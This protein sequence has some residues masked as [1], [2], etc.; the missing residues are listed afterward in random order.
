LA[1][2]QD[3]SRRALAHHVYEVEGAYTVTVTA[4]PQDGQTA[5][6]E[7]VAQIGSGEARLDGDDR[8]ETAISVS[9]DSFPDDG[10]ADAVLLA[11]ADQFADALSAAT[12]AFIEDAP[13]LL[14]GSDRLPAD[15]VAELARALGDSGT[16]YL[17]GGEAAIDP[18]IEQGLVDLGYEVVRLAG[19]D[20]IATALA[21]AEFVLATGAEVEEVVLA[22]AGDYPDALAGAAYAA[23]NDALILLTD[24]A[25]LDP[26]VAELLQQLGADMPVI[27]A[28]GAAAISDAVADELSALGFTVT[29]VDGADRFET[30][31]NLAEEGYDGSDTVV[32]A[33]GRTF[34]DALAGAAHAARLDAP[35]LLVSDVLPPAVAEFLAA[36]ADTLDTVYVLGG[37]GAVPDDVLDAAAALIGG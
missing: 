20:R 18:A 2:G 23:Q 30:A 28:G 3:G 5:V 31:A 36:H 26:R 9:Q 6:V 22:A 21:I 11:R 12:L 1:R 27:I 35:V 16:V 13:V 15:V 24:G 32:L 4:T 34:P 19:T 7:V 14:T 17:L 33:T 29:R 10:S 37:M 25:A 8:I